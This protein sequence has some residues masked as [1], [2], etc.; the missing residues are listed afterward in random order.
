MLATPPS[1]R[2]ALQTSCMYNKTLSK[3][4]V[5]AQLEKAEK[6]RVVTVT[7]EEALSG[8]MGLYCPACISHPQDTQPPLR[9]SKPPDGRSAMLSPARRQRAGSIDPQKVKPSTDSLDVASKP[10]CKRCAN[11]LHKSLLVEV[12]DG[13]SP[14]S[15]LGCK[16]SAEAH[17]RLAE[18]FVANLATDRALAE[19]NVVV[20]PT[21]TGESAYESTGFSLRFT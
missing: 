1:F 2:A 16:Y 6:H 4:D 18:G 5:L 10:D 3:A 12:T 15:E 9:R 20:V 14:H 13:A 11:P 21:G 17:K 7:L 8:H 19:A